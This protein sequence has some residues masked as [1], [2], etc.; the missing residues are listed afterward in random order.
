MGIKRDGHKFFFRELGGTTVHIANNVGIEG[1]FSFGLNF[2]YAFA[3][4]MSARG[5]F[6]FFES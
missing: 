3:F 1:Y 4:I 2:F 5:K 6:N